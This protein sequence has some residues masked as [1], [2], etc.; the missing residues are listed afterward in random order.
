MGS[1]LMHLLIADRVATELNIVDRGRI[2]LGSIAPD[3]DEVKGE[4]DFKGLGIHSLTVL[5]LSMD[6]LLQNTMRVSLIHF[7]LDT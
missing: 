5:H 4:T 7:I 1:R 2:L 3:G 6:A